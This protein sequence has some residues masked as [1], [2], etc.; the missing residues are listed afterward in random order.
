MRMPIRQ[1]AEWALLP[2]FAEW[3]LTLV[4]WRVV[5]L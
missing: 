5:F 4:D 3:T 1:N 2:A